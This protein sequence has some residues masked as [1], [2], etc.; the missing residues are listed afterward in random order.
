MSDATPTGEGWPPPPPAQ[1]PY[2]GLLPRFGARLLDGLIIGITVVVVF[3]VIPG[4]EIGGVVY[5]LVSSVAYFSYFAFLES[6]RGSTF[7][8]QALGLRVAGPDG[9]S[10]VTMEAAARRNAWTLIGILG[11]LPVIGVLAGLASLA[12]VIAIAV[13]ISSD[14]RKQGLHDKFADTLVLGRS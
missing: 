8:K 1:G 11:A 14:E 6:S 12:I 4:L 5:S 9:T 2:G 7:G 10:P 3:A 13:T